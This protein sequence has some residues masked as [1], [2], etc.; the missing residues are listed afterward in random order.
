MSGLYRAD[1]QI[2]GASPQKSITSVPIAERI[3]EGEKMAEYIKR[4][5]LME[6]VGRWQLNTR[7]AIAEMIMS[8]PSADVVSREDYEGLELVCKNYEEALKDAVDELEESDRN[9]FE[10]PSCSVCHCGLVLFIIDENNALIKPNFC[11][12]CGAKIESEEEQE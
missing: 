6:R 4:E 12:N 5:D 11:P 2:V 7:E 1:V 3:C 10:N 8:V 9:E